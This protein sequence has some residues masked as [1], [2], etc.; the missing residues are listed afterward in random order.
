MPIV[1]VLQVTI[2]VE[3]SIDFVPVIVCEL[4]VVGLVTAL[5]VGMAGGVVS[6][7]IVDE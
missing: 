5:M 7:V 4:T 1:A 3:V 6:S 2:I